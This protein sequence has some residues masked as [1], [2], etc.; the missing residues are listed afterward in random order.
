M[1]DW[2]YGMGVVMYGIGAVLIIL[3]ARVRGRNMLE[4][5]EDMRCN[6]YAGIPDINWYSTSFLIFAIIFIIFLATNWIPLNYYPS[7]SDWV[8]ILQGVIDYFTRII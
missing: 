1:F 6:M 3:I 7:S 8:L 4:L 2:L 5:K